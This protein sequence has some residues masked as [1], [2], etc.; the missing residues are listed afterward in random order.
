MSLPGAV[1]SD[2]NATAAAVE[3]VWAELSDAD[4][5]A[6]HQYCCHQRHG[7]EQQLVVDRITLRIQALTRR[8]RKA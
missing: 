4:K 1:A 7:S 8:M 2:T 6:F 5:I 3:R